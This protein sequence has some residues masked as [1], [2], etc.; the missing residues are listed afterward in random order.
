MHNFHKYFSYTQKKITHSSKNLT[1][2]YPLI[3]IRS[4]DLVDDVLL[5]FLA[6][7]IIRLFIVSCSSEIVL[8]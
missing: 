1:N 4:L 7:Q 3:I 5:K 6:K 2:P 8:D